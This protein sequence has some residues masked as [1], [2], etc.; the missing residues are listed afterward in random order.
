MITVKDMCNWLDIN[1]VDYTHEGVQ[2]IYDA[3][4]EAKSDMI[5]KLRKHPNW[6]EDAMAIVLKE[7]SYNRGFN[8]KAIKKFYG[9][10]TVQINE[11][12][13]KINKNKYVEELNNELIAIKGIIN[14]YQNF[15]NKYFR[16]LKVNPLIDGDPMIYTV[17]DRIKVVESKL[18]N[19]DEF[20][21]FDVEK[22]VATRYRKVTDALSVFF[23][24]ENFLATKEQANKVNEI[25]DLKAVEGQKISKIIRKICCTVNLDKITDIRDMGSYTK[26]MGFNREYAMLT[27]EINPFTFKKITVISVN[28][29]DYWSMSHGK[30]WVSCHYVG[31]NDDG[32]YSSGTESYMLDNVSLIYYIID[33]EYKG[34]EFYSQPKERRC[35]FCVNPDGNSI[36]ESRVYPDGRDGGDET[37]AGQ[38]R[39]VMQKI[40]ADCWDKNNYWNFKKGKAICK[41][42]TETIGTHYPDYTYYDDC[43]VSINKD[44]K[45]PIKIVIGHTPICPV[46]GNE[47]ENEDNIICNEC[48]DRYSCDRCGY[49]IYPDDEIYCEDNGC[50]YCCDSCAENDGVHYCSDD[51]EWHDEDNCFYD[52]YSCEWY[53]GEPEVIAENGS[54]FAS[55]GNAYDADYNQDEDGDWYPCDELIYCEKEDIRVHEDTDYIKTYDGNYFSCESSAHY[56]DYYED[57]EGNWYH[58]DKLTYCEDE[59]VYV[60]IEDAITTSD[61]NSY[62]SKDK[63]IEYGY[64]EVDGEWIKEVA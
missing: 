40:V 30:K 35:V 4:L 64:H 63:A 46:C 60:L 22:D 41:E 19:Y 48:N 7:E 49:R 3:W 29:L 10:V 37:L 21:G 24:A 6:D 2:E 31:N 39:N 16:V 1:R 36:L 38:F 55:Y 27:D 56:Y 23:D 42:L 26:D 34:N 32:C 28:P 5:E 57:I 44:N 51:Y 58:E 52:D 43:N 62:S 47:H 54:K 25:L 53:S 17:K 9:W 61:D 13:R 33:E 15:L 59:D 50:H 11:E 14:N 8:K 20:F 45:T 18:S 12:L